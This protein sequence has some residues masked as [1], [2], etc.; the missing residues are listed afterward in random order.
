MAGRMGQ[1]K[2]TTKGLRVIAIDD[3]KNELHLSGPVPGTPKSLL[4]IKRISEKKG[5]ENVES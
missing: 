2:L 4:I 3:N 5:L 1:D